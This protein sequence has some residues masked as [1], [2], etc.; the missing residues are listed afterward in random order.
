MSFISKSIFLAL[1]TA[2]LLD[3]SIEQL[4]HIL[5][6]SL[7]I[8]C[9]P[10]AD[11]SYDDM[12]SVEGPVNQWNG[13]YSNKIF[14]NR[15]LMENKIVICDDIQDSPDFL[16]KSFWISHSDPDAYSILDNLMQERNLDSIILCGFHEQMCVLSRP[17]GYHHL[18]SRYN[19]YIEWNL[20]CPFP[21]EN[22]REEQLLQRAKE[23]YKYIDM[24]SIEK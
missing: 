9:D 15:H 2:M 24:L 13:H 3:Y 12:L 4:K 11:Q 18:P 17:L 7:W 1:N 14:E 10:W 6:T 5:N 21:R 8:I 20:T 22:W 19:R 23:K 16:K